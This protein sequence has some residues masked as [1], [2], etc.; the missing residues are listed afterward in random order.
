MPLRPQTRA[1]RVT[2]S[3]YAAIVHAVDQAPVVHIDESGNSGENLFDPE[4]PVFV[5]A[6]AHIAESEATRLASSLAGGADE[7]HYTKLRKRASGQ[8]RILDFIRDPA[9]DATSVRASVH[10]KPY[11]AQAKFVDLL[12]EPVAHAAGRDLYADDGALELSFIFYTMGRQASPTYWDRMMSAFVEFVW[13]PSAATAV[14]LVDLME[15]ATDE[16]GDHP[17]GELLAM[18]PRDPLLLLAWHGRAPGEQSADALDPAL[19]AA[20]EQVRWWGERLGPFLLVYDESR[21]MGRWSARLQ[22]LSDP[23]VAAEYVVTPTNRMSALALAGLAPATSHDSP[24]VQVADV[25]AGAVADLLRAV[26]RDGD[27]GE[28]HLKLRAAK[29]L[30]FVDHFVWPPDERLLDELREQGVI[31]ADPSEE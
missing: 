3:E 26:V 27:L 20:V 10:H 8:R 4:Q 19:S 17:V 23:A 28:W 14:A 6:A 11:M 13:R 31:Q 29:V 1:G 12:F 16:S 7:A 30:R 25:V 24:Q 22:A 5:L 18:I 15:L 2:S 9:L 21:L